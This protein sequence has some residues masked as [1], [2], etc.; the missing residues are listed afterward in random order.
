[1]N[2]L[3]NNIK[4]YYL[5]QSKKKHLIPTEQSPLADDQY[6]LLESF[7]HDL[8]C[9]L[10][11]NQTTNNKSYVAVWICYVTNQLFNPSSTDTEL[12]GGINN[13]SMARYDKPS[14]ESA[15]L[16]RVS[17]ILRS[18]RK[19]RIDLHANLNL[20]VPWA[21]PSLPSPFLFVVFFRE[22]L[23]KHL[24]LEYLQHQCPEPA[25]TSV[26]HFT[27]WLLDPYP[28]ICILFFVFRQHL[29]FVPKWHQS[30]TNELQGRRCENPFTV[31]K[32]AS[33]NENHRTSQ[34]HSDLWPLVN[35]RG[36]VRIKIQR[37]PSWGFQK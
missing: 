18:W 21:P 36:L 8:Q 17:V 9:C 7:C 28:D 24:Y 13:V 31:T 27:N 34:K 19:L 14:I 35:D 37:K 29:D 32:I 23:L 15:V 12:C 5:F 2:I 16:P 4:K 6:C 1:M 26:R 20:F 11:R 10:I 25:E 30:R 3:F 33:P 22:D